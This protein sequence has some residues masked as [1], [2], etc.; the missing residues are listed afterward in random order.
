M[1][2]DAG[3]DGLLREGSRLVVLAAEAGGEG[4]LSAAIAIPVLAVFGCLLGAADAI[5]IYESIVR[6]KKDPGV[7]VSRVQETFLNFRS[8]STLPETGSMTT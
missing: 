6:Q 2:R 7:A 1:L 8:R 4:T 5:R 3:L